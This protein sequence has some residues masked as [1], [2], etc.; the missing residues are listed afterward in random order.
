MHRFYADPRNSDSNC[1]FL[2]PEDSIHALKVLRMRAGDLAEIISREQRYTA[3]IENITGSMVELHPL[4]VLPSTE[5]HLCITLFQGLPKGDKMD[6]IVQKAVELGVS[7]II[8]VSFSRCVVRFS[9]KEAC[10]KQERWQK[11]AR[12]AGKQSGRCRI[13]DILSP[14]SIQALP[15]YV[16][17]CERTAVPWEECTAGGPVAF[18][19]RNPSLLSL[20][21]V[22]GPEGGIASEEMHFLSGLGCEPV[23]LGKRILR[24]ETAGLAALSVFF[25]LY[26]EME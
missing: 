15:D 24:T 13:P 21:V 5:P 23:T 25:G 26:G 20:G 1:F 19:R 9:E 22:I 7:R 6:W 16:S 18:A 10:R 11:I 17:L 4:S 14:V 3:R 12:E 2:T 8:P